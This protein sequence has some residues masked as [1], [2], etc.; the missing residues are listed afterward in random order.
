MSVDERDPVRL[1]DEGSEASPALRAMLRAGRAEVPSAEAL[2][3]LSARLPSGT[4]GP[5]GAGPGGA[6][7]GGATAGWLA[8]AGIVGVVIV[9]VVLRSPGPE[10]RPLEAPEP[11]EVKPLPSAPEV[12][13]PP[14]EPPPAPERPTVPSPPR[15]SSPTPAAPSAPSET[16]TPRPSV[17]DELALVSAARAALSTDPTSALL[18][19]D[20]HATTFPDGQLSQEAEVVAV[21]ALVGLGRGDE[22]RARVDRFRA[23][24][25]SSAHLRRLEGMVGGTPVGRPE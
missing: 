19:A 25:P 3:R 4:G 18:L 6:S 24:W 13:S 23:R 21:Q 14:P 10:V 5:G 7:S 15:P 1:G 20:E 8:A 11:V 22:A 12:T 17:A 16:P 9:G 2:G